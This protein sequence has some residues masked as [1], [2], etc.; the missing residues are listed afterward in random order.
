MRD[1]EYSLNHAV[2]GSKQILMPN[3]LLF[4]FVAANTVWLSKSFFLFCLARL[5]FQ[6][7]TTGVKHYT[8]MTWTWHDN[9]EF[10]CYCNKNRKLNFHTNVIFGRLN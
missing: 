8:S 1:C 5:K 6:L 2:A 7:Y 9:Q 4:H 3:S 10:W